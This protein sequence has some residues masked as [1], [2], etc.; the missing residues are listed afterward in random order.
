MTNA[1]MIVPRQTTDY[2]CGPTALAVVATL[3]TPPGKCCAD[4]KSIADAVGARPRLGADT[5][6]L[7]RWAQAYL[8][9]TSHGEYTWRG[10]L[11]IWNIRNGLSAIGHYVVVLGSRGDIVRYYDP[12]YARTLEMPIHEIDW[13]AGIED[14]KRWSINFGGKF[15]IY[16]FWEQ[17]LVGAATEDGHAEGGI[18]PQWL[19]RSANAWLERK[20]AKIQNCAP[21]SA[22]MPESVE[23]TRGAFNGSVPFD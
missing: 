1:M 4:E 20:S 23:V 15:G 7:V 18:C 21:K 11:S 22:K 16:D 9:V 10:G 6:E 12:F 8:P 2:T 3:L 14:K 17:I 5:A 19:L 13:R